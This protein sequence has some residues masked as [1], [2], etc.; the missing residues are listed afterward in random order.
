LHI[1]PYVTLHSALNHS[2]IF[3]VILHP[4]KQPQFHGGTLRPSTE[5]HIL[6]NAENFE[7]ERNWLGTHFRLLALVF[8]AFIGGLIA[9]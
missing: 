1:R 4:A 5:T 3:R 9:A 2:F 7:K 6:H 8:Q